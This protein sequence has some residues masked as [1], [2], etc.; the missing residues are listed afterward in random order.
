MKLPLEGIRVLDHGM[1]WA[2]PWL[3][4]LLADFGAEVIKVESIQIFDMSRGP[5][6][7]I[8][9]VSIYPGKDPGERSYNRRAV[10]HYWNQNKYGITLDL[11]RPHG[12][13]IYKRLVKISDVV[14]E[15]FPPSVMK[16]FGLDYPALREV[17]PDIIMLSM[18][19]YGA[20]GPEKDYRAFGVS[21]EQMCGIAALTGYSEEAGP[22]KSGMDYG[23]PTAGSIAAGL[24]IAALHYRRRTGKGQWID[25]SQS[26]ATSLFIGEALMD[27]TMNR[28]IWQRM[29]NR[30]PSMAPHGCYR[31]R[32]G[33][34]PPD[35]RWVAIAVSSDE[36]WQN[37]CSAMGNPTWAKDERF[38]TVIG[39]LENR[40]E[41]DRLIE[42]WTIQHDH[43]EVMHMLQRA[44][45]PAGAVLDGKEIAEE[46][47]LKERGFFQTGTHPEVGEVTHPGPIARLSKTPVTIR[48]LA[49]AL[50]EHNEYVFRELLG[51]T[52]EEI[53]ELEGEQ[54]I[55]SIP[56]PGA[57]RL[58]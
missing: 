54:I 3:G 11:S 48:R 25:V 46:P 7:G 33:E 20:T 18:P 6:V 19:G 44:G 35:D 56:L 34:Q 9:G 22:M 55:G 26:E 53:A 14:T 58:Y 15:N 31:C 27:Y 2:G 39:R 8:P 52:T 5:I 29:G 16:K 47:H 38:A 45:V 42:G 30:H 23:D 4:K 12:V 40:E 1:I 50:G 21:Q 32:G 13:E 41:L 17:K 24:V 49:P 36:E 51:M 10:F 28:R 37:L 43:Y 57:D